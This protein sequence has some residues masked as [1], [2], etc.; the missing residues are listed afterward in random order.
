M[1]RKVTREELANSITHAIGVVLSL[2]G[3]SVLAV[4]SSVHNNALHTISVSVYGVSLLSVYVSSTFHHVVTSARLKRI[5]LTFDHACIYLLIAGTYTPFMVTTLKGSTGATLLGVVWT[6][7]LA[8]IL[9]KTLFRIHSSLRHELVSIGF[10]LAMGWLVLFVL[11]PFTAQ[12]APAGLVLLLAGGLCYSIGLIFFMIG[13]V[14]Y[15]HAVWHVFVLTG[16]ALHYF[17]VLWYA[18]P[19]AP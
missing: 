11:K 8:G 13:R 12:I 14:A 10:Y 5:S 19:R 15:S 3:L 6:L 4:Q 1:L 9:W 2:V 18:T 7:G 16:S 17:S